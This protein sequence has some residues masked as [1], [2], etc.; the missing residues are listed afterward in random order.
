METRVAK[1]KAGVVHCCT[2]RD[3]YLFILYCSAL[4][5]L[6]HAL[7]ELAH[8]VLRFTVNT[9]SLVRAQSST[10]TRARTHNTPSDQTTQARDGR[11]RETRK[12]ISISHISQSDARSPN[13]KHLNTYLETSPFHRKRGPW[14]W[15]PYLRSPTQDPGMEI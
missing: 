10:S 3:L 9:W 7:L 1:R 5:R 2:C 6:T 15:R 12:Q 4:I 14:T 11:E 8:W 13:C